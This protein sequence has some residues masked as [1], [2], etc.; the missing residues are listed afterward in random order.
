MANT[1]T[2]LRKNDCYRFAL[3]DEYRFIYKRINALCEFLSYLYVH[4]FLRI[5]KQNEEKVDFIQLYDL[6]CGKCKFDILLIGISLKLFSL[7]RFIKL[8]GLTLCFYIVLCPK[9]A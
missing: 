3:F 1:S 5:S 8:C 2:L 9:I 6:Q 4:F 7:I